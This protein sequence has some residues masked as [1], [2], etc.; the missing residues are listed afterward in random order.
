MPRWR[1]ALASSVVCCLGLLAGS[2]GFAQPFR[3]GGEFQVNAYTNNSQSY[4]DIAVHKTTGDF[5]ITWT[6]ANDGYGAGVLA[7]RF[8]ST[9][10]RQGLQ[11]PVNTHTTSTQHRSSVASESNGDF[12]VVWQSFRQDS[13]GDP[14]YGVFARRFTSD[15]TAL[16]TEFMVNTY[17]VNDQEYPRV[18]SDADGDFLVV[19][20][21]TGQDSTGFGGS[22][23]ARGFSSS[24]TPLA[25]EFRVNTRTIDNQFRPAVASDADGDFVVTWESNQQEAPGSSYGV[26]AQRF[27]SALVPQAAEFRV[28]TYTVGPQAN[29]AVAA[30]ADGD[31]VVTW[32]SLNQES[33]GSSA[34]DNGIFARRFNSAGVAQ[35]VEFQVNLHTLERQR[36][37]RIAADNDG[38]FVVTWESQYQDGD[39]EGVFARRVTGNT[40]FGPEFQ[41]NSYTANGQKAQ[42]VGFDSD[43]DFVVTWFNKAAQDGSAFGI[44]AQRFKLPPLATLDIDGNGL[45]E[46]LTDGLLNLRH[47]FGFSGSTLTSG[48]VGV[49]CSRCAA[50]D[51][52]AYLNGLGLVMDIDNNGAL[53]P[54]TD[55]LL[56]L[57]FTF[58][59]TGTT[60]TNG[61][62]AGNCVTRCDASTILPYLQMLATPGG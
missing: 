48:A 59:F 10:A 43:A 57:R 36:F 30:R 51:I 2:A 53:D 50:A 35:A 6:D 27:N 19:W 58:G 32:N 31:F 60:L 55:G 28:N 12:V 40:A 34:G 39:Y 14:H 22:I 4:P 33:P 45:V 20:Q 38:D 25:T 54:L 21:S 37:P 41:V 13:A 1:A 16:A 26:F 23:F 52:T 49:S 17:T 56:V 29:P 7:Q 15:G 44:F 9:G 8:D 62:V 46:P 47:R 42:A 5:V 3:Q 11:F 61:A 18:A 24:G